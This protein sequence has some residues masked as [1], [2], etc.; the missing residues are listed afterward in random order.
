M[1]KHVIH[2]HS[3]VPGKIPSVSQLNYGE[4]AV[5]YA[6]GSEAL[7]IRNSD[8]E[9]VQ[10][11]FNL[12]SGGVGKVDSDSDGTGEIFNSYDTGGNAATGSF[13]HAEGDATSATGRCTH[14]EGNQVLAAGIT[15]HAEGNMTHAM[16]VA[17][18][19]EGLLTYAMGSGSHAE[20]GGTSGI[21]ASSHVEGSGT[22]A[23]NTAEHACGQFNFSIPESADP[24]YGGSIFTVG[25]GESAGER[26]NAIMVDR[27]GGVY[28][29]GLGRY[30]GT[31]TTGSTPTTGAITTPPMTLSG[32]LSSI[33]D[34]LLVQI[35]A[36]QARI[37]QLTPLKYS[38]NQIV[39][40]F[41]PGMGIKRDNFNT[42]GNTRKYETSTTMSDAIFDNIL[43]ACQSNRPVI[44]TGVITGS[45][46]SVNTSC[47]MDYV[48]MT[49]ACT[50]ASY[51]YSSG[52]TPI[53]SLTLT[54]PPVEVDDCGTSTISKTIPTRTVAGFLI[55]RRGDVATYYMADI[56]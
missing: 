23:Y 40:N 17:A 25:V 20:G 56:G 24:K 14:A 3:S 45:T 49:A 34:E 2:A 33:Y 35:Q 21:G 29:Y 38:L 30:D 4:I 55:L 53:L 27:T 26:K 12:V 37:E 41:N 6:S 47:Q 32:V 13:S 10:I 9:I 16:G 43:S 18:H 8:D 7:S 42:S 31:S 50:V 22:V 46:Y 19:S 44:V 39:R 28:I 52:S 51:S 48:E 54:L 36:L 11:P 5:N 1:S 15:S